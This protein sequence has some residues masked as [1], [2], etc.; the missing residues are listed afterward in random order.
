VN[1]IPP[2][3][4]VLHSALHMA[5]AVATPST[6]IVAEP[7]LSSS[8]SQRSTGFTDLPHDNTFVTICHKCGESVA[9]PVVDVINRLQ[10]GRLH[11][12]C[13]TQ[14]C[15]AI[16]CHSSSLSSHTLYGNAPAA[17]TVRYPQHGEEEDDADMGIF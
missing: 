7:E 15:N 12:R 3:V 17:E 5:V 8:V 10:S 14:Q 1:A 9:E 11:I 16:V 2:S 4:P 6:T 13:Q